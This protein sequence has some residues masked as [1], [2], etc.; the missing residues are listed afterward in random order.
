MFFCYAA[1]LACEQQE[2]RLQAAGAAAVTGG[3][4]AQVSGSM[5]YCC[6]I[7]VIFG[8]SSVTMC[9]A[10]SRATGCCCSSCWHKRTHCT[11]EWLFFY[12]SATFMLSLVQQAA[13]QAQPKAGLQAAAGA[14]AGAGGRTA[15]VSR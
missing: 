14:A 7:G 10:G 11:S 15:Q 1:A 3:R 2:A 12:I 5:L 4:T 8:G 13:L 9:A 6:D